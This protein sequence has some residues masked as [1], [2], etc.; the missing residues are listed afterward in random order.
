MTQQ[1]TYRRKPF[2]LCV[3]DYGFAVVPGVLDPT[4]IA[5]LIGAVET[6]PRPAYGLVKGNPYGVRNLL[7]ISPAVRYLAWSSHV[8]ELVRAVIGPGTFPVRGI[9]F[10]KNPDAN[11]K[12]PFHQ[13]LTIAVQSRIDVEGF[14][15]WSVKEGIAHTQAPVGLLERML[16]VR[17]H[18][19]DCT[20]DDGPLRV[21]PGTHRFGRLDSAGIDELRARGTETAVTARAGDAILMRPLLLHASSP[22]AQ[23]SHRRVI[24]LEYAAEPLPGGLR[25]Y[26][27]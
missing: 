9:F 3:E 23:P 16:A 22:A 27:S 21:L 13:D 8:M 6:L 24:H 20:E 10:D 12:V 11:W 5:E 15:P 17:L 4:T 1:T 18:L 25:W 19:D 14:G 7:R 26:E 2:H